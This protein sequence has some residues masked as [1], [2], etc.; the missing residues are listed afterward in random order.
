MV[1][2]GLYIVIRSTQLFYLT[3]TVHVSTTKGHLQVPQSKH[4]YQTAT[5]TFTF[6]YMSL[7]SAYNSFA[8][9]F[10]DNTNIHPITQV[11]IE[12]ELQFI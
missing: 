12:F 1:Y 3:I 8:S 6:P 5:P 9:G 11:K 10:V 7:S 2:E 4:I